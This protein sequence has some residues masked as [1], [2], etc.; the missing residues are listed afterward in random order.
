MSRNGTLSGGAPAD[1]GTSTPSVDQVA[2]AV[3]RATARTAGAVA[4]TGIPVAQAPSA[5]TA[6][7]PAGLEPPRTPDY[8]PPI[9]AAGP[10]YRVLE[11]TVID[12]VLTNRLDGAMATPVN[13]LVTNA[14][15][16]TPVGRCFCRPARGCSA[17]P[18][19]CRCS[20]SLAWQSRSTG[21]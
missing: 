18:R 1:T 3:V 17:R 4:G 20:A 8:T 10:L 6:A 5:T 16:S 14:L 13:C 15:Y 7:P 12:T 19:R 9:G 11:G 21:C 2:D